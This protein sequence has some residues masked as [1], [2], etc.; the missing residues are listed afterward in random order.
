MHDITNSF[1]D[2]K[3]K[4]E[5]PFLKNWYIHVAFSLYSHFFCRNH[6]SDT[7]VQTT[8]A[9]MAIGKPIDH[10]SIPFFKF[11]PNMEVMNVGKR[12]IM[13]SDV[14]RRITVFILLLIMFAYVSIVESRMLM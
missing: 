7:A 12:I 11:M 1:Y 9:T 2:E 4:K 3:Q 6:H 14:K 10:S 5:N 13:F 8:Q